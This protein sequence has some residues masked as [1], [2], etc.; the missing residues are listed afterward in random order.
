VRP[1]SGG[2]TLIRIDGVSRFFGATAA[3]ADVSLEIGAG[4]FFAL[5]GPSGCGKTTLLR[6]IAGLEAP[7]AGSIAI[8]GAEMTAVPPWERPVNTVFQS[9]ALFPHLSVASNIAFGLKQE[10]L[11]KPEIEARVAEMLTLVELEGLGGRKPH[12]LSGGQRQRVALARALAKR[13][14]ALLLDEPLAALDRRLRDQVR[15]ELAA[16][17]RR[18][19]I[20]FIFVTHDQDEAMSLAD[21][22]AIMRDGVLMQVGTPREVYERPSSRYIADFLGRANVIAGRAGGRDGAFL[23]IDTD[24]GVTLRA[25]DERPI[26]DGTPLWLAVRPENLSL[27][28]GEPA[29]RLPGVVRESAYAG[30]VSRYEIEIGGGLILRAVLPNRHGE[31]ASRPGR[32]A[33]VQVSWPADAGVVLTE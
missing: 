20:T 21:R 24:I 1:V 12:Q 23:R 10:G 30:D 6:L 31:S 3:V 17:Q 9:Y 32:G 29:N 25:R 2:S 26:A 4:E 16:I 22:L 11:P 7:D 13:P 14:K 15:S 18:L 27:G 33:P 8:D 28:A 5:L 19:G